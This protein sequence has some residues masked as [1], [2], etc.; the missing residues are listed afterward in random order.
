[1]N[2]GRKAKHAK[3]STTYDE[4][5]LCRGMRLNGPQVEQA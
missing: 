2:S 4:Q 3:A 1:N 5:L